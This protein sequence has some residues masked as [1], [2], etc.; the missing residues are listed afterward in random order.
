MLEATSVEHHHLIG[1][2]SAAAAATAVDI[3]KESR[4]IGTGTMPSSRNVCQ[5]QKPFLLL[6][7]PISQL[8]LIFVVFGVL[9]ICIFLSLPSFEKSEFDRIMTIPNNLKQ[10]KEMTLPLSTYAHHS[11]FRVMSALFCLYIFLQ[12]F[13]VPGTI[14]LNILSGALFGLPVAFLLTLIAGTAGASCAFIL[15]K[16]LGKGLI[17]RYFSDK[18]NLFKTQIDKNKDNL[19]YFLLFLRIS[20]MLPNWFINICSPL[21]NIPFSYFLL[22]TLFGI[23]PQTAISVN[24]GSKIHDLVDD[25][26]SGNPLLNMNTVLTLFAI[27]FMSLIPVL[28]K[29]RKH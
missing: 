9:L 18:L 16:L 29:K 24:I 14:F 25:E 4:Q 27:A 28:L 7:H 12:T 10:V 26:M 11:Y 6:H 17:E 19:F 5:T 21:L 13:S 23:A 22:A 3:I 20:P 15:S 1:G 2:K 8:M